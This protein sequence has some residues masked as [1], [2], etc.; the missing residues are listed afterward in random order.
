MKISVLE[1][2]I[3]FGKKNSSSYC[4]I[5]L[6]LRDAGLQLPQ[7]A[8]NVI[9]VVKQGPLCNSVRK[10]PLSALLFIKRFD[11]GMSVTPMSFELDI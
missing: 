3:L 1:N 6:A 4:P 5:A 7:V 11:A 9:Q 2:H 10:T 8:E